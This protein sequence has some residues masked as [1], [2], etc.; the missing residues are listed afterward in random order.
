M[1]DH[2]WLRMSCWGMISPRP[3]LKIPCWGQDVKAGEGLVQ[4]VP[5]SRVFLQLQISVTNGFCV[6]LEHPCVPMLG[7]R[8]HQRET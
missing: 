2:P 1:E 4:P 8:P 6:T 7:M 3:Q 5:W